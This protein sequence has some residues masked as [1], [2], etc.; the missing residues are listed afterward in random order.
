MYV[1]R[2]T[3]IRKHSNVFW[4]TFRYAEEPSD[5]ISFLD[6]S[7]IFFVDVPLRCF[8]VILGARATDRVVYSILKGHVSN[9]CTIYIVVFWTSAI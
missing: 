5:W 4:S 6:T 7:Y 2:Y 8:S 1:V 9:D 3:T